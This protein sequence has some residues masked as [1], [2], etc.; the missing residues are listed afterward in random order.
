MGQLASRLPQTLAALPAMTDTDDL[1]PPVAGLTPPIDL[2]TV[3][4]DRLAFYL[5]G[6]APV[7]LDVFADECTQDPSAVRRAI[8]TQFDSEVTVDD[9]GVVRVSDV[10]RNLVTS[11]GRDL[12]Q[13][14]RDQLDQGTAAVERGDHDEA[15]PHLRAAASSFTSLRDRFAAVSY[16]PE[17]LDRLATTAARKHDTAAK[18]AAKSVI[19]YQA[20]RFVRHGEAAADLTDDNPTAAA[21]EYQRAHAAITTA[22]EAATEYNESRLHDDSPQLDV[23]PLVERRASLEE[24]YPDLAIAATDTPTDD[25]DPSRTDPDSTAADTSQSGATDPDPT[26]NTPSPPGD[27]IESTRADA[28]SRNE[29][30]NRSTRTDKSTDVESAET[31]P[32]GDS[33]DD[34]I[35]AP[36]RQLGVDTD[37]LTPTQLK[38]LA[39]AGYTS[40]DGLATATSSELTAVSLIGPAAAERIRERAQLY[41]DN[42]PTVGQS[43]A[44]TTQDGEN[45]SRSTDSATPPQET[46]AS[47]SDTDQ[48]ATDRTTTS[49]TLQDLGDKLH[50][51]GL[52]KLTQLKRAGYTSVDDLQGVS[53]AD[54]TKVNKIGPTTAE[55]IVQSLSDD[56]SETTRHSHAATLGLDQEVESASDAITSTPDSNHHDSPAI[57]PTLAEQLDPQ[58]FEHSWDTIPENE[59]LEGQ[60]LGRVVDIDYP[61]NDRKDATV[62][63]EDRLGQDVRLEIWTTHDFNTDLH[64]GE[65]YA[66]EH[67]R[68][69]VWGTDSGTPTKRLSTTKDFGV[70]ELGSAFD[71]DADR[72]STTS[73]EAT[74]ST[75]STTEQSSASS[76]READSATTDASSSSTTATTDESPDTD[77]PSGDIFDDIMDDFDDL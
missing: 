3:G 17:K 40:L 11:A 68:G 65:W 48:T 47:E 52:A 64:R 37:R 49:Q 77:A 36:L 34:D 8:M 28:P 57:D 56:H 63:L 24:Q 26:R 31:G 72:S 2:E 42:D 27:E 69:K 74:A 25:V 13:A 14:G 62:Y 66:L 76:S 22:I 30:T 33:T 38:F 46:G 59:R 44:T 73:T 5:A 61:E 15:V 29:P 10:A 1:T 58:A 16:E 50:H 6:H 21:N 39:K 18:T 43:S 7:D 70:I 51:V 19:N 54:L 55:Q 23:S 45:S 60:F 67:A 32:T 71:P 4:R 75:T 35:P 9:A 41:A 12:L 53:K 20:T